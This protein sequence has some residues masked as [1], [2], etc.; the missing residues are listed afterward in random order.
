VAIAPPLTGKSLGHHSRPALRDAGLDQLVHE[1]RQLTEPDLDLLTLP[2]RASLRT[3]S[4]SWSDTSPSGF[5][6]L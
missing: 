5:A 4:S 2:E 3:G 1:H 6:K